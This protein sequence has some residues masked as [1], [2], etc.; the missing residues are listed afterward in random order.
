MKLRNP[1]ILLLTATIWGVAFVA[2]SV[3]MDYVGPFTFLCARS[4]IGG[5]VLLP[6]VA[7]LEKNG[8]GH[9]EESPAERRKARKTLLLG[10][11][12]CG[13]AL[14]SA[15]AFQQFGL[16]Y[17]TV[18]KSGF[19]TACYILIVPLIGLFFGRK[20]GKL[21][22]C[23]VALALAGLYFLCLT[24]GFSINAGDLLM[25]VCAVLFS[26]HILVIDHFS[27]RTDGVK[28]S[29]IQF[30]VCA[31][32]AAVGMALF[33]HPSWSALLAAWKPVL[34]AG[35]LSSGAG[36]TL[37]IIGQKG[38]NPT[39]ASLI[40]SLESVISVIAGWLILGQALSPR[41]IFGCVLMFSAIVL[42]QLPQKNTQ[43]NAQN[44]VV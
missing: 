32:V 38:M 39:V 5:I 12:C 44:A 30:F 27:P 42:A 18:G 36:Y 41:E 23:G 11:V 1:L 34:Y 7:V 24:D 21:V 13:L 33:E 31:A 2:Q 40:M 22:W 9:A 8:P 4:V 43:N 19:L 15:S 20:C 14:C 35:A 3:G 6:V 16:L 10:G 26:V 17:T 25:I 28:M 29:C 37:Q